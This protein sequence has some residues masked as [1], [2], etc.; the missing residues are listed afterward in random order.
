MFW[1]LVVPGP[2]EDVD[3]LRVLEW[4]GDVGRRF[5]VGAMIV[6]LETHK[7]VVEVRA[8][9][10]GILRSILCE[11]GA[12]EKIGRPLALLS[13]DP[14]RTFARLAGCSSDRGW[15]TSK[16]RRRQGTETRH[17]TRVQYAQYFAARLRLHRTAGVDAIGQMDHSAEL[18]RDRVEIDDIDIPLTREVVQHQ[19]EILGVDARQGR[20][21]RPIVR[22]VVVNRLVTHRRHDILY[23]DLRV[24][25]RANRVD[26]HAVVALNVRGRSLHALE[27]LAATT[28]A[29]PGRDL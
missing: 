15:S 21:H 16:L 24:S 14:V 7:A 19:V 2:I 11:A 4:H 18:R 26:E 27:T 8:G 9:Q 28:E 1:K 29:P 10:S 6:E 22:R 5:D 17:A 20:A 25:P 13:D 3:E 23:E 12:W